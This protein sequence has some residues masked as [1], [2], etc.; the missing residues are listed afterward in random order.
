MLFCVSKG[1]L[2]ESTWVHKIRIP[3]SHALLITLLFWGLFLAGTA[4]FSLVQASTDVTGII[5]SDITWTKADSPYN[6][7]GSITVASGV[8]LTIE[9]GTVV[10]LNGYHLQVNGTLVARGTS[11]DPIDFHGGTPI[12]TGGWAITTGDNDYSVVF[13]PSSTNW[14]QQ[15]QSGCIVENAVI[16]NLVI[17][18]GSPK[19]SENFLGNIDINGGNPEISNNTVLGGI[20]VYAGSAV[21][22]NNTVSQQYHY[23][24]RYEGAI[25][26]Q[27]YDRNNNIIIITRKAT[28]VVSGNVI[29]GNI[30]QAGGGIR[31]ETQ[32]AT[33][34]NN[35]I[36]GCGVG[37]GFYEYYGNAVI[38]DNT[39]YDSKVGINLNDTLL[40]ADD[41]VAVAISIQRNLIRN[42]TYG[43]AITVPAII[44]NNAIEDNLVGIVTDVLLSTCYNNIEGNNQSI[45]LLS[46]NNFNASNNWWGTTDISTINQTIYDS[47]YDSNLG[48]VTFIPFLTEQNPEIPE[49]SSWLLLPLFFV[50][51]IVVVVVRRKLIR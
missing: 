24:I 25:V 36:Y 1:V 48:T 14:S 19:I 47:K 10:D 21:I 26:A 6:L 13:S 50:A 7:T 9:P 33:I 45:Y 3:L 8:T 28:P 27:R 34:T 22:A 37:I 42:N 35:T 17:N 12:S 15:I 39:I 31:F 4:S 46:S 2:L 18:G 32:N 23:F 5:S 30:S 49:F 20:G 40:L 43:I 44:E 29:L 11:S 41:E 38:S 16:G 51:T